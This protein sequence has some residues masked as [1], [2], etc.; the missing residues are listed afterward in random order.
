MQEIPLTDARARLG[1]L[2]DQVRFSGKPVFLTRSGKPA[3]ALLPRYVYEQWQAQREKAFQV[4]D[5]IWTLNLGQPMTDEE[6]MA[7]A[8]EAV[9]QARTEIASERAAAASVESN[10]EPATT[11]V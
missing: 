9:R 11:G 8:V 2:V 7:W 3:V 4:L 5:D 1:E 6:S 10:S